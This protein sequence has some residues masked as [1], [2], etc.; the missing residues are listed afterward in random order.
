MSYVVS[1]GRYRTP[2]TAATYTMDYTNDL[3]DRAIEKKYFEN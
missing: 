2:M 1:R 3:V